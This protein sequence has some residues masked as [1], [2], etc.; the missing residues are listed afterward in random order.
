MGNRRLIATIV[1]C[2]LVLGGV[3]GLSGGSPPAEGSEF[4]SVDAEAGECFRGEGFEVEGRIDF[5][6]DEG[7]RALVLVPLVPDA[8]GAYSLPDSLVPL[9]GEATRAEREEALATCVQRL[10]EQLGLPNQPVLPAR[11]PLAADR[12]AVLEACL[13]DNGLLSRYSEIEY[14][15]TEDGFAAVEGVHPDL[16]ADEAQGFFARVRD[17]VALDQS[18]AR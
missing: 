13:R 15:E 3:V 12:V 1:G 7:A 5:S 9:E 16:G 4:R 11:K 18:S 6:V 2:G 14:Y 17:C 10:K 8:A